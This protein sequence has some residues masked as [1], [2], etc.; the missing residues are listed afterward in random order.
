MLNDDFKDILRIFLDEKVEFLI[1]G[2][3]ALAAHGLPRATGDIDFWVMPSPENAS[4]VFRALTKF[5]APM[6]EIDARDFEFEG[7][8]YQIGVPPRRI[9]IVTEVSGL[10]FAEAFAKSDRLEFAGFDVRIPCV[11]DLI[12]NKKATGRPKDL[13]DVEVLERFALGEG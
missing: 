8:I 7:V 10:R 6:Q 11:N 5:G 4:A 1:I 3:Y 9:D 13:I 2:A 12:T